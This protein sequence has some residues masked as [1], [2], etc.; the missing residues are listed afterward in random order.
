MEITQESSSSSNL[1]NG[2]EDWENDPYLKQY[3]EEE[4]RLKV[5]TELEEK[6]RKEKEIQDEKNVNNSPNKEEE[7]EEETKYIAPVLDGRNM[8]FKTRI[9]NEYLL[10]SLCEGYFKDAITIKECLHTFCKSCIYKY[11]AEKDDCPRCGVN[12]GTNPFELIK[13]D[14]QMQSIVDKL[15]PELELKEIQLERD[16]YKERGIEFQEPNLSLSKTTEI[17]TKRT[18]GEFKDDTPLNPEP[19][20]KIKKSE[21]LN[22]FYSD[23]VGFELVTDET[24]ADRIVSKLEKPFIR[25]SAK[26]TVLHLKKYLKKEVEH[27]R[28]R[29]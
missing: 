7:V 10:C 26:V 20:K 8:T 14:R 1:K 3:Y 18:S 16:F 4:A 2:M 15:F 19:T 13:Y 22:K 28:K 29:T 17:T 12:L 9:L 11:L 23:E 6:E 25:T 5:Q 27:K 21:I 24:E